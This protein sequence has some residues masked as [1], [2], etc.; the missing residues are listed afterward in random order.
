MAVKSVIYT[1]STQ[2]QSFTHS[3]HNT[4]GI[5]T[6]LQIPG[7]TTKEVIVLS[8]LIGD[9]SKVFDLCSYLKH[10][11]PSR[12]YSMQQELFA[13]TTHQKKNKTFTDT[14]I[15]LAR[16]A[17]L[18]QYHHCSNHFIEHHHFYNILSNNADQ[19]FDF[20]AP[21]T[22]LFLLEKHHW[23]TAQQKALKII[24]HCHQLDIKMTHY[25]ADDYPLLLRM[26]P[27]PPPIIYYQG[28][29]PI[30]PCIAIVGTRT[31]HSWSVASTEDCTRLAIH[32]NFGIVS[33]LALGIDTHAHKSSLDQ[34]GYTLAVLAGGLD[35]ITPKSNQLLASNILEQGGALLSEYPPQTP[36]K[37]GMFV[38]R[39]RLQSALSI[40]TVIIQSPLKG[41]SMH[42]A[43]FTL[44]QRRHLAIPHCP[45]GVLQ[46][47]KQGNHSF[48]G[49][50]ALLYSSWPQCR[51]D[52][53]ALK[54]LSLAS[55][56]YYTLNKH[57][58]VLAENLQDHQSFVSA[59]QRYHVSY[60][61][62][63]HKACQFYHELQKFKDEFIM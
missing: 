60:R 24:E 4:L 48:D 62:L 27:S 19:N 40:A 47:C 53:P 54:D 6:L 30:H 57:Q 39:N 45:S 55:Q 31:P 51:I 28:Q 14:K 8:L 10:R 63:S 29:L 34:Q 15:R 35:C 50:Q 37:P 11:S 16:L 56:D 18:A 49:T 5:L 44:D 26:I 41:G 61:D 58:Q 2:D 13:Y 43:R 12:S 33:G 46:V 21:Q 7:I 25:L 32:Q 38:S 42:T 22:R 59:L 17:Q 3:L 52:I 1:N 23:K 20:L 9:Y 36:I